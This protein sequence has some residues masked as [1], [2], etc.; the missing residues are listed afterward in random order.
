MNLNLAPFIEGANIPFRTIDGKLVKRVYFHNS[1]T[2]LPL[3]PVTAKINSS[4]PYYTYLHDQTI[5]GQ[6]MTK[7][8]EEVRKI[9]LQYVGGDATKD[10]AIFIRCTTSGIN[11]LSD[12]LYQEDPDQVLITTP[13]E[14]MANYLP[15]KVRFKTEL[16]KLTPDGNICLEDL[17]NKLNTY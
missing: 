15:Y 4:L 2:T 11:L 12:L 8:Y 3:K 5:P 16:V 1:A 14:H 17:E 9:V 6:K 13:M 7:M 10:V